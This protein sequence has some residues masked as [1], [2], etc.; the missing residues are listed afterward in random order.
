MANL[1]EAIIRKDLSKCINEM[2]LGRDVNYQVSI[3]FD[4][5][6]GCNADF[7]EPQKFKAISQDELRFHLENDLKNYF[8]DDDEFEEMFDSVRNGGSYEFV[9]KG[10]KVT[11]SVEI[12]EHYTG[13]KAHAVMRPFSIVGTATANIRDS[14]N[15]T[16]EFHVI[17]PAEK[18]DG[19][20]ANQIIDAFQ[21]VFKEKFISITNNFDDLPSFA[22]DNTRI[23]NGN[24][25]SDVIISGLNEDQIEK[26]RSLPWKAFE[27][28]EI[29]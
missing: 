26:Y 25:R 11:V 9:A 14:Y 8:D 13:N 18:F 22:F 24:V 17:A 21:K 29:N 19:N 20:N 28:M 16:I 4:P 23:V 7:L 2:E 27:E 15:C 5:L 12:D 1:N 10:Q 6:S 3:V